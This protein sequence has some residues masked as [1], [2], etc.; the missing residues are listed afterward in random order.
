MNI[1]HQ[2]FYCNSNEN[3]I[4]FYKPKKMYKT[5]IIVRKI[6]NNV[7]NNDIIILVC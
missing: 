7:K 2:L 1:F 6:R 4:N 3:S 5:L